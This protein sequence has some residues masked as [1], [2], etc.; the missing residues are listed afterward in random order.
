MSVLGEEIG[1]RGFALPYL[2]KRRSAL[3]SSL[4][5]GTI[6]TV[7]HLPFWIILGVPHLSV[8]DNCK[9]RVLGMFGR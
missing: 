8:V 4:L 9:A 7:W 5:L 1:W 6:H 2:Q 3:Q